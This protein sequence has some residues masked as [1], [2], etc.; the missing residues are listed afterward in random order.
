MNSIDNSL[1]LKDFQTVLSSSSCLNASFLNKSDHY[2]TS[3]KYPGVEMSKV[4][5]V[6]LLLTSLNDQLLNEL[7][8][9]QLTKLYHDLPESPPSIEALRIYITTPFLTE[10]DENMKTTEQTFHMMLFA[11]A[12][13]INRLKKEAA[14]RVLDYWFAWAGV[15]FFKSLI[16]AYKNIVIHII[17]L[18][19]VTIESEVIYR[20]N[21]LKASMLFLQKLHKVSFFENLFHE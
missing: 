20:H 12:Q 21:L 18:K 14:G 11:Y 10:F 2:S 5:D 7:V 4:K 19:V 8:V 13:S 15:E 3:N 6:H 16:K 1:K 9:T 17:N